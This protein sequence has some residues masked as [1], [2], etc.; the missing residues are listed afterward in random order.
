MFLVP[1]SFSFSVPQESWKSVSPLWCHEEDT[2]TFL[3]EV[4]DN[5]HTQYDF[6][7]AES[8]FSATLTSLLHWSS[9]FAKTHS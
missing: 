5:S 3:L 7:A 2:D 1:S 6:S 4:S 8:D 9:Q